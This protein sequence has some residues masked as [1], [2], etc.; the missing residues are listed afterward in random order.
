MNDHI[1][2]RAKSCCSILIRTLS[3]LG[4]VS[5]V[6]TY[7]ESHN[8]ICKEEGKNKSIVEKDCTVDLSSALGCPPRLSF[9]SFTKAEDK[10]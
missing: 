6:S 2:E 9:L 10:V 3:F 8:P 5:H 1:M 7:I 4:F